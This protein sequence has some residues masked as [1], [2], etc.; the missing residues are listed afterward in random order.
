M[1]IALVGGA[2]QQQFQATVM[3]FAIT[4]ATPVAIEAADID[5]D[6]RGGPR[7]SDGL[8]R[9]YPDREEGVWNVTQE[10]EVPA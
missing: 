5:R 7:N 3:A 2:G 8:L 9:W 1:A 4:Q 6:L 10:T